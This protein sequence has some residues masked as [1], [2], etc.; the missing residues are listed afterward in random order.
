[1]NRRCLLLIWSSAGLL[2]LGRRNLCLDKREVGRP[3]FPGVTT[4]EA[5]DGDTDM[6]I[7]VLGSYPEEELTLD[8]D[9]YPHL[10]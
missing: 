6:K 2:M 9:T 10:G 8:G 4:L 7:R 3:G 1:M 5:S